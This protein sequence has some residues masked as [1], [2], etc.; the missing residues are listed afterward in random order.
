MG[1]RRMPWVTAAIMALIYAC[2]TPVVLALM[3]NKNG[4]GAGVRAFSI[5][6]ARQAARAQAAK[7]PKPVN[8]KKFRQMFG[9]L[10]KSNAAF[11]I[12]RA[13]L[14]AIRLEYIG[15][16]AHLGLDDAALTAQLSG[17]LNALCHAIGCRARQGARVNVTPDFN[18]K[19]VEAEICAVLSLKAGDI[20]RALLAH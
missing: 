14:K 7:P 11:R 17:A 4:Y 1:A 9:K 2:N 12:A 19:C 10:L 20:L 5:A 15:V 13:V 3:I 16:N 18:Q 6:G 8:I